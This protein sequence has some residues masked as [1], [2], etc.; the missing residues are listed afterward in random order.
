VE[1]CIRKR[2]ELRKRV[3]GKSVDSLKDYEKPID[4][5][6]LLTEINRISEVIDGNCMI[7]FLPYSVL[8]LFMIFLI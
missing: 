7:L 2:S 5:K 8:I 6:D 4:N 3:K 1:E